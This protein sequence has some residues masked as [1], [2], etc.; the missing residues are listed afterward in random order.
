MKN[1][2]ATTRAR[3][4]VLLPFLLSL[5]ALSAF[6]RP[7]DDDAG[8]VI[9]QTEPATYPQSLAI[10]GVSTGTVRLAV[11]VDAEGKLVDCLVLAYT[12]P[13]FADAAV[14][15]VKKW[16]YEPARVDGRPR[17]SRVD[18]MFN[19]KSGLVASVRNLDA[20]YVRDILPEGFVFRT[21]AL[22]DLDRIPTPITVVKPVPPEN[23]LPK[24]KERVVTVDF[25]IDEEGT[26]RIPAIDRASRDDGFAAAAVAAVEQWHFE[27]PLR[28]GR[29]V[30]VEVQQDIR[31]VGKQ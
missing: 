19:F 8:L 24:G 31:F 5:G 17:K 14:K 10:N 15:A 26:V 28:K 25:Y 21:Y 11:S 29:P 22:R 1:F 7:D 4:R 13:A 20:S 16:N 18:L 30:V 9:E 6:G 2:P 27:P 23:A 12:D 3:L